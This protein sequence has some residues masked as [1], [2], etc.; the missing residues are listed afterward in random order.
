MKKPI[1]AGIFGTIETDIANDVITRLLN[2]AKKKLAS[3]WTI[4]LATAIG[5][6]YT[7]R[8]RPFA[9]C[10]GV[11][12]KEKARVKSNRK[13]MAAIRLSLRLIV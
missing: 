6:V 5:I 10:A 11:S 12:L 7:N 3:G 8:D 13:R 1:I 4:K 2:A 9:N